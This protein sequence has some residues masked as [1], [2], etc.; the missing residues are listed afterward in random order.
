MK[1]EC[2][3]ICISILLFSLITEISM[4]CLKCSRRFYY[5]IMIGSYSINY[6]TFYLFPGVLSLLR[7]FV[8]LITLFTI[9]IEIF[10]W[11]FFTL[12]III[13][14]SNLLLWCHEFLW[15]FHNLIINITSMARDL[16][17]HFHQLYTTHR[18]NNT[19]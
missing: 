3:I 7:R 5:C 16:E 15:E 2:N 8:P 10:I 9:A 13:F 4:M 19:T 6:L 18:E 17:S 14:S 1:K 12:I 11:V